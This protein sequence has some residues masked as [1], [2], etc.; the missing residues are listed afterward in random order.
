MSGAVLM[1]TAQFWVLELCLSSTCSCF[2]AE[3][4]AA[5]ELC[6]APAGAREELLLCSPVHGQL[7][8]SCFGKSR[9]NMG[10]GRD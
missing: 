4:R 1:H 3:P 8:Q 5:L 7:L 10:F 9:G 6:P 2:T